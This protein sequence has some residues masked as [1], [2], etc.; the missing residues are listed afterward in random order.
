[1]TKIVATI[2]PACDA[3][4][5]LRLMVEAGMNVA[6]LNLSHGSHDDHARRIDRIRSAADALGANVA[7]MAD[8]RGME[9]RTGGLAGGAVELRPEEPF[10]L[11][12]DPRD[13]GPDG[14][15]VSHPGLPKEVSP[16]SR[17][18]LD[19]GAIELLVVEVKPETVVCRVVRGG[20][21]ESRRGVNL[22]DDAIQRHGLDEADRADLL[23]AA[24][25]GADYV[26]ASFVQNAGDVRAIQALLEDAA[27]PIPVIAKI[28]NREGQRN[29]DS[30]VAV[31]AGTMVARGDLGVEIPAEEV[32]LVQKRIIHT[33]VASG[34]PVITATQMLSSMEQRERPTRAEVSDVANAILDG[35]SAL[36]LSGETAVGR[37]PVEAV[38]TMARIA[39]RTEASLDDYG[40]LQR[41]EPEPSNVMTESAS[42]A[43]ITMAHHL[44]AAAIVALT[45]SGFTPRSI[46]KHRP[47]CPILAVTPAAWVVRALAINWGVKALHY[48]GERCDEAMIAFAL[49]WLRS[50]GHARAGDVV[51]ATTG[52]SSEPGTTN[53]I[54]VVPV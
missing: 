17:V 10:R 8:T 31:A 50:Q 48:E 21:L 29:L 39:E 40:H 34:R 49:D 32:P 24:G 12:A 35:T 6:R 22:P 33:T 11:Y 51:V 30:I 42:Q 7:I 15:S 4:E 47:R 14:V 23:F 54:S 44:G 25:H 5:T 2:G 43:A 38:R 9:I 16:G 3:P 26:A 1:M 41:I 28:E 45:E 18:L 27:A 20:R 52:V 13:G 36:M 53:R 19:D 46:S 37:F